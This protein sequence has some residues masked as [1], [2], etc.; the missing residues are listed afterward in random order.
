M[1][2]IKELYKEFDLDLISQEENK[3]I[4]NHNYPSSKKKKMK[5]MKIKKKYNLIYLKK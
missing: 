2:L 1:S 3:N 4:I 5:K